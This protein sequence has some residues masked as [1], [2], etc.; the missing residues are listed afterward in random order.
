MLQVNIG[1]YSSDGAC[2]II[3]QVLAASGACP[4]AEEETENSNHGKGISKHK[5]PSN[6]G[7]CYGPLLNYYDTRSYYVDILSSWPACAEITAEYLNSS[8]VMKA[9][10]IK[11]MYRSYSEC[12]DA[13]QYLMV[14]YGLGVQSQIVNILEAGVKVTFYNGQYDFVCNHIGTETMLDQL[15]WSG[16]KDFKDAP[17]YV[18]VLNDTV[19]L[20]GG[21]GK[22]A[23]R[24]VPAGYGRTTQD[25]RLTF[26]MVIGGSHMVPMDVPHSAYDL[27]RR[28]VH[29]LPFFDFQQEIHVTTVKEAQKQK[30]LDQAAMER[31][32]NPS[33]SSA[34]YLSSGVL[35][36]LVSVGAVV[37]ASFRRWS[38]TRRQSYE[39]IT[40]MA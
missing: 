22:K 32:A 40:E 21:M 10:N 34:G 28:V 20:A 15:P 36:G 33:G 25:G 11:K 39:I 8:A 27:I 1:D 2:N 38:A 29:Q 18:W 14:L 3:G 12:D 24:K 26:L 13:G 4:L 7:T 37:Y 30:A 17:G 23:V 35:L 16:K 19:P 6:N 31:S 9:I 5:G